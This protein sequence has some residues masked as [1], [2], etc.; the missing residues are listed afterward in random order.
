MKIA[1]RHPRENGRDYAMRVIRDGIISLE[2]EPGSVISDRELATEMNLSRT[3]VREALLELAKVKIVE[4]Y[5]Q[6]GSIVAHGSK[7]PLSGHLSWLSYIRQQGC[8]YHLKVR[9]LPFLLF[10]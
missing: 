3:P 5:P 4:I 2:L 6:R 1:D 9:A 10:R 7:L 8:R